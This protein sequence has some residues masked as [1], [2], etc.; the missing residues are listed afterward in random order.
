MRIHFRWN[1]NEMIKIFDL[2]SVLEQK[3][4]TLRPEVIIV[5]YGQFFITQVREKGDF[6]PSYDNPFNASI[7]ISGN[8][9][10]W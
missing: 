10:T 8:L 2:Y 1:R 7:K 6:N 4:Y 3:T 9:C 5:A